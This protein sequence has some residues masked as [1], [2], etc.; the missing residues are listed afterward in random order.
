MESRQPSFP[1]VRKTVLVVDNDPQSLRIVDVSLRRAG[2]DVHTASDGTAAAAVIDQVPPPDLVIADVDLP[3]LDGFELCRRTKS[4]TRTAAMPFIFLA[5]PQPSNKMRAFELGADDFLSKPVF[6]K[7]VV[8]RVGAL[9]QRHERERLSSRDS[10]ADHASGSLDDLSTI[11]LLQSIATNGKSGVLHLRSLAGTQGEVYFRRGSVVDAEVGR[12]SG[13]NAVYRLLSWNEGRFEIEWRNIRRRDAVALPAPALLMEGM[14]RLDEWT[15]LT[16]LLPPLETVFQ[17]DYRLLAERLAD[18]PDEVNAILRLFDG[19]R[20]AM[21][22][23]DD[24]GLSDLD[25]LTVIGKL[26]SEGLIRNITAKPADEDDKA[27]P[28]LDGWLGQSAEPALPAAAPA[29]SASVDQSS[30]RRV[31]DAPP[32]GRP[33]S[34]PAPAP[35]AARPPPTSPTPEW[36]GRTPD[37]HPPARL[38]GDD[39]APHG[40]HPNEPAVVIPFPTATTPVARQ[41][42]VSATGGPVAA[43]AGEISN[44]V[45]TSAPSTPPG[46]AAPL[47]TPST[48][49]LTAAP[50]GVATPR[51]TDPGLGPLPRVPAVPAPMSLRPT[52]APA[53]PEHPVSGAHPVAAALPPEEPPARAAPPVAAPAPAR[54]DS[55]PRVPVLPFSDSASRWMTEGDEIHTSRSRSEAL[56]E[57]GMPSRFRGWALIAGVVIVAGGSLLAARS[58]SGHKAEPVVVTLPPASAPPSVE[59]PAPGATPPGATAPGTTAPTTAPASTPPASPAPAENAAAL[60]GGNAAIGAANGNAEPRPGAP[61]PAGEGA[62]VPADFAALLATCQSAF[63]GGHMKEATTTCTAAV[64]ANPESAKATALLAHAEFNRSHRKEA[65]SWAEKAIKI[66]P[67]VADAY[68]I[69][70][71]VQQ[72]AGRNG[73][74]KSAYRK[75]L[76]L[77]PRGQYA[78]DLRAIVNSL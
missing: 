9:L 31:S 20:T 5:R 21:Q 26:N 2:Y 58:F 24:C 29:P 28:D 33:A 48:P 59:P 41:T 77:A 4:S 37:P 63:N 45:A 62:A 67:K 8:A 32:T 10:D 70:G 18:I 61:A 64:E 74:A 14:R 46:A 6:V 7:E 68:V 44:G 3:G 66:D 23:I 75:Y 42:L 19:M 43:V 38:D 12:L 49:S 78:A 57:L 56:E 54:R 11:D 36:G 16:Q 52:S 35:A 72:D 73:E 51:S 39:Q 27:G 40:F 22:V 60:P 47:L 55:A 15:R 1:S 53:E 17:V 50:S 34:E 30:L 69:I 65:L 13:A 76:E 71:G 25:A